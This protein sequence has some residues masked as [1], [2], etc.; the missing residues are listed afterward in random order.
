MGMLPFGEPIARIQHHVDD[1][2]AKDGKIC[3]ILDALSSLTKLHGRS[4]DKIGITPQYPSWSEKIATG[5]A[6]L[7]SFLHVTD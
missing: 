4:F 7:T 5:I 3:A 2:G 6:A 1:G